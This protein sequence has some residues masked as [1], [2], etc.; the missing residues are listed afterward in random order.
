MEHFLLLFRGRDGRSL[1]QDADAYQAHLARLG[2]WMESLHPHGKVLS[3]E[4]LAPH[5]LLISHDK[6]VVTDGPY[7]EG[8]EMVGGYLRFQCT[9][10]EIALAWIQ[11]CPIFEVEGGSVELREIEAP[12]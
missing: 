6:Q 7:I 9:T 1:R 10:R 3:A 11:A 12:Q 8:K 4:P 5:A 2:A